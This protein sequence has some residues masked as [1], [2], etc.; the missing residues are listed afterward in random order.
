MASDRKR[1]ATGRE[2]ASH[3]KSKSAER[4]SG[5]RQRSD[6]VRALLE[7]EQVAFVQVSPWEYPEGTLRVP[8]TVSFEVEIDPPATI[9][10][11]NRYDQEL[12]HYV[13]RSGTS[14]ERLSFDELKAY[15]H[16]RVAT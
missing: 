2:W 7:A 12:N 14:S 10:L 6:R 8:R 9:K 13:V 16:E 15:V 3:W 1:K 11:D 5:L 4:K